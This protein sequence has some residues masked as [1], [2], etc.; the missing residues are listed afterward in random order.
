MLSNFCPFPKFYK[1]AGSFKF[2]P[3]FSIVG[4]FYI[5]VWWALILTMKTV[6]WHSLPGPKG[7]EADRSQLSIKPFCGIM[8]VIRLLW[9]SNVDS[10]WYSIQ[11]AVL[12]SKEI[13][14]YMWNLSCRLHFLD[15]CI[16]CSDIHQKYELIFFFFL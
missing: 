12:L 5:C 14:W 4:N 9:N 16:P 10:R 2:S 7:V 15:F 1:Q 3:F 8:T 6:K 11:W 13:N